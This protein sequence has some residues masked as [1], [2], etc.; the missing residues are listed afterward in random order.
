MT[1]KIA[2]YRTIA[3]QHGATLL[4]GRCP[5]ANTTLRL[6]CSCG[7]EFAKRARDIAG[8]QGKC[9]ACN[10]PRGEQHANYK[11]LSDPERAAR[12]TQT[13]LALHR[14]WERAVFTRDLHRCV[15]TGRKSSR[16]D[17]IVAHHLNSWAE[18]PEGRTDPANGVTLLRSLH[19]AFHKQYGSACTVADF[20]AFRASYARTE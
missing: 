11:P 20:E 2:L 6:R 17:P 15:I 13:R 19:K 10:R 1:S 5:S 9:P 4:S 3:S 18:H 8:A 16:R 12:D 7:S 14:T